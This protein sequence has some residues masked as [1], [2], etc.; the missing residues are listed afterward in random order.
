MV[1]NIPGFGM[2]CLHKQV[3]DSNNCFAVR[4][5]GAAV[6]WFRVVRGEDGVSDR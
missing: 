4:L 5:K 2:Y 6:L 3:D 1:F